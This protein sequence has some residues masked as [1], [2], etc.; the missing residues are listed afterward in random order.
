VRRFAFLMML[1][2]LVAGC[3]SQGAAS[4]PAISNVLPQT[5]DLVRS[6][7]ASSSP[8]FAGADSLVIVQSVLV[9]HGS[10]KLYNR[11]GRRRVVS[12]T[13]TNGE[14]GPITYDSHNGLLYEYISDLGSIGSVV[15]VYDSQGDVQATTGAWG[16]PPGLTIGI[17]FDPHSNVIYIAT[18]SEVVGKTVDLN[19]YDEE[20]NQLGAYQIPIPS[21]EWDVYGMGFDPKDGLVL[22][23]YCNDQTSGEVLAYNEQGK[24]VPRAGTFQGHGCTTRFTFDTKTATVYGVSDGVVDAWDTNGNAVTLSPGFPSNDFYQITYDASN[25]RFYGYGGNLNALVAMFDDQGNQIPTPGTFGNSNEY[26]TGIAIG[27]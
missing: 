4:G 12:G 19:S 18:L 16:V 1:A 20:G 9:D 6:R 23:S 7:A 25:D 3:A 22:M 27:F 15:Y 11:S 13:F 24:R 2:G 17:A 14:G 10:L 26:I 8:S 21:T 5:Q